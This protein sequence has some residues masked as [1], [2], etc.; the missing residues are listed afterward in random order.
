[1]L[2]EKQTQFDK[3]KQAACE[4]RSSP[5]ETANFVRRK[6]AII[7]AIIGVTQACP[8]AVAFF[9]PT[10]QTVPDSPANDENIIKPPILS[11]EEDLGDSSLAQSGQVDDERDQ[12]ASLLQTNFD[13]NGNLPPPKRQCTAQPDSTVKCTRVVVKGITTAVKQAEAPWQASLWWYKYTDYKPSEFAL[14]PEWDRRHKCGGTLIA[15]EWVLT[16]A[17][18]VTGDYAGY[19]FKVRLG[20]TNLNDNVGKLYQ[21][22]GEP[23]H[24]PKY[25]GASKKHD[26]ALLHI[27]R[28]TLPGVRPVRLFGMG[29]AKTAL[30]DTPAKVLGY[31]KTRAGSQ[32]SL[33]LGGKVYIW[34]Q[35]DCENA[36]NG[37]YPGRI[38]ALVICANGP[39]TDSCQGDSGGPLMVGTEQYGVV[40]WGDGCAIAGNPGVYT[41][42]APYLSWI[43]ETTGG[44]AGHP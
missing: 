16:A 42:V 37:R 22:I 8:P 2:T 12:G 24:F 43:W 25:D 34:A 10:A 1:M 19:P 5:S 29:G 33:L 30:V 39:S 41:N 32:S 40:S 23:I 4:L 26:I 31:G 11:T 27:A 28:V 35:G 7:V 18:C 44:K 14:K 20:S 21:V 38:T 15:A 6:M 17:H 36:Y 9:Q 3:F 13:E